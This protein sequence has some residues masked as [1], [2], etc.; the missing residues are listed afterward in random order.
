[1]QSSNDIKT[2]KIFVSI[3]LFVT[4]MLLMLAYMSPRTIY[5]TEV[6]Y[7]DSSP[8]KLIDML[9]NPESFKLWNPWQQYDTSIVYSVEYK[10]GS[11]VSKLYWL[12]PTH[13]LSKGHLLIKKSGDNKLTIEADLAEQLQGTFEFTAYKND[14]GSTTIR[15][16]FSSD[17]TIDPIKRLNGLIMPYYFRS[18]MKKALELLKSNIEKD[19]YLR[20]NP[21]KLHLPNINN[22]ILAT[23]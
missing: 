6:I 10:A 18:D 9:H 12:S 15:M 3:V 17:F 14:A 13:S 23:R 16:D 22:D 21:N 20:E 8:N 11:D 5:L 7:V 19:P 1:M 2:S 4:A